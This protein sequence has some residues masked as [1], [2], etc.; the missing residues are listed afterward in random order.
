MTWVKITQKRVILYPTLGARLNSAAAAEI[1]FPILEPSPKNL[2][3][4]GAKVYT[5]SMVA[6]LG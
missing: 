6:E 1:F 5:V 4:Y 3:H 2:S